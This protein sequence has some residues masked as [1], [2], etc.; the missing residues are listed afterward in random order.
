M[1]GRQWLNCSRFGFG[2][3]LSLLRNVFK[4]R[5]CRIQKRRCARVRLPALNNQIDIVR[6]DLQRAGLPAGLF[7]GNNC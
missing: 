7:R 3:S 5:C 1:Y 4:A 2:F 6:I